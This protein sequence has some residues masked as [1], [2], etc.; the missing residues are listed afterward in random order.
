MG[1]GDDGGK[2]SMSAG[3]ASS[4]IGGEAK[5]TAGA[6][7]SNTGGSTTALAGPSSSGELRHFLQGVTALEA[8][9]SNLGFNDEEDGAGDF[10]INSAI[11]A[12]SEGTIAIIAIDN[13]NK[14]L[15]SALEQVPPTAVAGDVDDNDD[16]IS[17]VS[18]FE[19]IDIFAPPGRLGVVMSTINN[20]AVMHQIKNSSVLYDK[21]L[22]SDA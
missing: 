13:N 21:L 17:A 22:A 1:T 3:S 7:G 18:T 2:V 20:T 11:D 8:V 5:L 12:V 10:K 19:L 15:S 16:S 6:S 4:E 9:N 14:D